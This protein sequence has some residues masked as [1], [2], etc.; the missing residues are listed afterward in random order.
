MTHENEAT[1]RQQLEQ[2]WADYDPMERIIRE[3]DECYDLARTVAAALRTTEGVWAEPAPPNLDGAVILSYGLE[4]EPLHYTAAGPAART[5]VLLLGQWMMEPGRVTAACVDAFLG[6]VA[7]DYAAHAWMI[8][9]Q[10]RVAG[11]AFTVRDLDDFA[12]GLG[13]NVRDM[14]EDWWE[15]VVRLL[16]ATHLSPAVKERLSV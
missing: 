8:A 13:S 15:N 9:A 3:P 12:A 5:S 7:Q 16:R 2:F 1:I 14:A 10:H 4:I 6:Q 11:A